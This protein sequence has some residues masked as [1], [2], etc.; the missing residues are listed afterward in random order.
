VDAVGAFEAVGLEGVGDHAGG[1][2]GEGADLGEGPFVEGQAAG[3]SRMLFSRQSLRMRSLSEG[4]L[5]SKRYL[6]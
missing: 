1:V 5:G 4:S 2:G 6:L 3:A